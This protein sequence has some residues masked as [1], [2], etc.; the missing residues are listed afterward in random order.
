MNK[1]FKVIWNHTTQAFVVVSELSR[2]K[3]KQ[4]SKSE[5]GIKLAPLTLALGLATGCLIGKEAVAARYIAGGGVTSSGGNT[6]GTAVGQNASVTGSYGS[7]YGYNAKAINSYTTAIGSGATANAEGSTAVGKNATASGG[8]DVAVGNNS[9]AVGNQSV[10]IGQDSVAGEGINGK[11]VAIGYQS[12]AIQASTIAIGNNATASQLGTIAMG[13]RANATASTAISIGYESNALQSDTIAI[14]KESKAQSIDSIAL[15]RKSNALGRQSISIGADSSVAVTAPDGIAIGRNAVASHRNSI[16]LGESSTT[17]NAVGTDS[18]TVNGISYGGFA[19]S[20]PDSVFSIGD[21][22]FAR[23]IVNV[24]AGQI[25]PES[26]DAINGSQLYQVVKNGAWEL[27]TGGTKRDAVAWGDKVNFISSD[28]SVT[29]GA[30][31][32][33]DGK[34][35]N[36]DL[37]AAVASSS[38]V[39]SNNGEQRDEIKNNDNVNFVDGSNTKAVVTTK[40]GTVSDVTYHVTG[41]PVQYTDKNGNPVVKVNGKYYK[42]DANGSPTN[43]EVAAG[44]LVINAVNPAAAPNAIGAPTTITNVVSGLTNYTGTGPI[45]GLRDLTNTTKTP[46]TTVAT[47]GDLRN[48]GWIVSTAA[49]SGGAATYT[50]SVKNANEV[51]FIGEN[52]IVVSGKDTGDVR[53]ISVKGTKFET[54]TTEDGYEITI[55]YPDKPA[56]TLIVKNGKNGENGKDGTSVTYKRTDDGT[57]IIY[58]KDPVTGEETEITRILKGEKGET[59]DKGATGETGDKG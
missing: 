14:G 54:K 22:A 11:A 29:I 9:T 18:A 43:E 28:N 8:S 23:Q 55:N 57:V 35:T 56:E 33:A 17:K 39:V 47:V 50:N 2:S 26:T 3:G 7:A 40:N 30:T 19:G 15:G 48:M 58:Q 52:G 45:T 37:K 13:T 24:A 10:A 44:D 21:S 5:K 41:L 25:A 59:G 36:I 46:D 31:T 20:T 38:F 16:A 1:I 51:K 12:R 4:S 53:E 42:V 49:A 34:T 32:S 27:Q 6:E